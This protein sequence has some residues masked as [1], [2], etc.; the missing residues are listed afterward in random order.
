MLNQ[1]RS[2]PISSSIVRKRMP[3]GVCNAPWLLTE[4][5][6]QTL[7][8]IPELLVY[9]YDLCLLSATWENHVKSLESIFVAS[10]TAGLTLK[11]SK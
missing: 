4:M 9:L 10:Q 7:G 6:H 8:H 1:L 3:F 5:A 11:P 2:L